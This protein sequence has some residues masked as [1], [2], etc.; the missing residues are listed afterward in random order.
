MRFSISVVMLCAWLVS[1]TSLSGHDN[2]I[3]YMSG[4]VGLNSDDPYATR[5]R[6]RGS[7]VGSK[8]LPNG[9]VEE[10]FRS[11]R[12]PTCRTFFE[13]DEKAKKIVGWRYTG[14]DSDCAITP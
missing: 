2:Y 9:N 14:S 6:Y 8:V 5:N 3:S 7:L 10:E 11:G 13:I 4:Q 12:G 1:C